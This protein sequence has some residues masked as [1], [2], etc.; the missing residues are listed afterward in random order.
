MSWRP[1]QGGILSRAHALC[2]KT[3]QLAERLCAVVPV[4]HSRPWVFRV[5]RGINPPPLSLLFSPPPWCPGVPRAL[6]NLCRVAV[7]RALGKYR[8]HLI[9]SLPLPDPI[10]K[11]L[12]Y[13]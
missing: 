2:S 12:L 9:P 3:G 1:G 11:F 6:L 8:L 13:E 7:R 10:K 4:G 5:R